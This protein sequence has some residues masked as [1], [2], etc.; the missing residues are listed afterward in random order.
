MWIQGIALIPLTC[1]WWGELSVICFFCWSRICMERSVSCWAKR[2]SDICKSSPLTSITGSNLHRKLQLSPKVTSASIHSLEDCT[3]T[4]NLDPGWY[5]STRNCRECL[6]LQTA[7]STFHLAAKKQ[8]GTKI[9]VNKLLLSRIQDE[10]TAKATLAFI[11]LHV[12]VLFLI[13]NDLEE[14]FC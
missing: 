13:H 1:F 4:S 6:T 14:D 5:T 7:D 3:T 10:L 9:A 2:E 12:S 8:A 11:V